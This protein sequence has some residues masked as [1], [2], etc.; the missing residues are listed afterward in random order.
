MVMHSSDLELAKQNIPVIYHFLKPKKIVLIS[1]RDALPQIN[2]M[3]LPYIKFLDEDSIAPSLSFKK[4]ETLIH[5]RCRHTKRAGWYFQQFLKMAYAEICEEKWYMVWDVDTIP[6]REL[7]FFTEEGTGILDIKS[8]YHKP[9]FQ[10][11]KKLL[12]I[13]KTIK[14]S[15]IS[16]HMLIN[17]NVMTELIKQIEGNKKIEGNRF[18]EKIIQV[19]SVRELKENGFS[20]YE[21]YGNFVLK[22]YPE[23]YT[24]RRLRTLREGK[25]LLGD[26]PNE[27]MLKWAGNSY[28]I[29][30]LEKYHRMNPVLGRC[31]KSFLHHF[32]SMEDMWNSYKKIYTGKYYE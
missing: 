1:G 16:E 12:D 3:K 30:S 9:Y 11:M 21:T 6:L 32:I 8:E 29:I 28:D 26:R 31:A 24:V 20:E 2:Q 23:I 10:T 17:K 27:E 14:E 18:F 4:I 7:P 25:I 22:N 19:L 15:F 13:N 5:L